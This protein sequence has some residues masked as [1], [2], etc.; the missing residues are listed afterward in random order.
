MFTAAARKPSSRHE[1]RSKR[2]WTSSTSASCVTTS[3]PSSSAASCSVPTIRPRRSSSCQEAELAG[4]REPHR[5]PRRQRCAVPDLGDRPDHGDPGRPRAYALGSVRRVDPADR[6]DGHRDREA[7]VEETLEPDRLAGV[8]LRRR[9]PDRPRTDVRRAGELRDRSFAARAGRDPER[10][11]CGYRALRTWIVL[12]EVDATAELER[13]IDI[14]VDDQLRPETGERAAQLDHF[15][16]GR[17]FETQLQHGRP[18]LG[19]RTTGLDIA[20]PA[21]CSLTAADDCLH[22]FTRPR[23]ALER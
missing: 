21:V 8:R 15:L 16:G 20:S 2:K 18:T 6:D 9:G 12:P 17:A 23:C 22:S 19:R 7:D 3:P 11:S 1:S 14:V 13:R 4:L 10:E 5:P